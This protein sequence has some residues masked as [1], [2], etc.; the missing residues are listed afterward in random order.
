[1]KEILLAIILMS[2]S[3]DALAK[4][5]TYTQTNQMDDEAKV[6]ARAVSENGKVTIFI[7]YYGIE[8]GNHIYALQIKNKNDIRG[9]G[10]IYKL[11]IDKE[12]AID[13][14][15]SDPF[16]DTRRAPRGGFPNPYDSA[17]IG[18]SNE[19][20]SELIKGN[21]LVV[22][23]SQTIGDYLQ[24][25]TFSLSGSKKAICKALTT[26]EVCKQ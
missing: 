8:Y 19:L 3:F 26:T 16:R 1:M 23:F 9:V 4:W 13:L 24:T 22:Q 6:I 14:I 21:K 17:S 10:S 12:K 20:I 2:V 7:Y 18:L 11:R 25:A 5:D 15:M